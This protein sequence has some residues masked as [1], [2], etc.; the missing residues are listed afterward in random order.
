M[1]TFSEEVSLGSPNIEVRCQIVTQDPLCENEIEELPGDVEEE[2]NDPDLTE[3][4][5]VICGNG[6]GW[7]EAPPVEMQD[8]SWEG[9]DADTSDIVQTVEN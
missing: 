2:R 3:G 5:E 4:K 8:E 6:G 1:I 9:V 7:D